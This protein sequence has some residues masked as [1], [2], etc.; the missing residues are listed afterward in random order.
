MKTV[1]GERLSPKA[2]FWWP[3]DVAQE[4]YRIRD[5]SGEDWDGKICSNGG[6]RG[7][8]PCPPVILET[9]FAKRECWG[10]KYEP[11]HGWC[12]DDEQIGD[13]CEDAEASTEPPDNGSEVP[14]S[15]DPESDFGFDSETF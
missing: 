15:A 11:R 13:E 7:K 14:N 10:P 12:P 2:D 5:D 9:E 1:E 8:H 3:A 6:F 4:N